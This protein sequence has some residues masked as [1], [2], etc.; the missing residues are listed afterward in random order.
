[1]FS[2]LFFIIWLLLINQ[3]CFLEVTSIIYKFCKII[4]YMSWLFELSA[5][6]NELLTIKYLSLWIYFSNLK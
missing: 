5:L 6:L 1:M 2:L 4:N 3:Y